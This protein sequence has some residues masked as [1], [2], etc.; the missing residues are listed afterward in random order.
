MA[1]SRE[2]LEKS[3]A[4]FAGSW[5]E[6]APESAPVSRDVDPDFADEFS[7]D[8]SVKSEV[9][10]AMP[11]KSPDLVTKLGDPEPEVKKEP[12][13]FKEAFAANRKAGEKTFEWNGKK[14]TTE[15]A[16]PK[17][18]A[19]APSQGEASKA[20]PMP[21]TE[22]KPKGFYADANKDLADGVKGAAAKFQ[23]KT[24]MG[25]SSPLSIPDD[26]DTKDFAK[27]A[28]GA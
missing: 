25:K 9:A 3:M 6:D 22:S 15:L 19:K 28:F 21:T 20:D 23:D 17:K 24:P 26:M 2:D 10:E 14:Y 13:S 11:V 8:E 16:K 5:H 1:T 12:I 7:K 18:I 4:D 27:R